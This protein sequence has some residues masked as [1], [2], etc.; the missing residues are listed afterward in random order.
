MPSS[1]SRGVAIADA[2][3]DDFQFVP[4]FYRTVIVPSFPP[5]ELET[6]EELIGGLRAGRSRLLIARDA[7][8]TI[9]GGAVGEYFPRSDI[10]LLAYLAVRPGDRG[11]GLGATLLQ[12]ARDA[13]MAELNPRLIVLEVEDPRE[14]TSSVAF[15]DPVARVR[16]YER[17]GVRALPLP[18][19]MPALSPGA[20]RVHRLMLMVLA[21][22]DVPPG[23]AA[24]DGQH[25]ARFIAEYFEQYEG[26]A[27]PGDSELDRL[28]AACARPGG[29]PLML[30]QELPAF[31]DRGGGS[32][33]DQAANAVPGAAP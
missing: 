28:L 33:Y 8:G 3:N 29:L 30:A 1:A 10:M 15:G 27:Q 26:P 5:D 18:Y 24:A 31:N 9:A 22:A 25:V 13:W 2:R 4:E 6:E 19:V 17:Y 11:N 32:S 21:G 14:A 23:T 7:D 20:E 16:F 12:A